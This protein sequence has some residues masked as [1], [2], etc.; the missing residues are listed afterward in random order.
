MSKPAEQM[1]GVF[2]MREKKSRVMKN[3]Q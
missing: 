1:V 3:E 2:L